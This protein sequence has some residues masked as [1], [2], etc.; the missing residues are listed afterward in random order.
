[1]AEVSSRVPPSIVGASAEEANRLLEIIRHNQLDRISQI[2]EKWFLV[3]PL[4]FAVWTT[5]E[6]AVNPRIRYT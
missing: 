2:V 4:L 1:M 3:E 5:H 6:V